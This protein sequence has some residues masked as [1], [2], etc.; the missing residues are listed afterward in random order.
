[1]RCSYREKQENRAMLFFL[2]GRTV[3][4]IQLPV[5]A[6]CAGPNIILNAPMYM[7]LGVGLYY[8]E[9][10]IL[11]LSDKIRAVVQFTINQRNSF[12]VFLIS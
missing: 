9:F 8:K 10:G 5:P 7:V 11:V 2:F 1:M 3:S 12:L 4:R 6:G